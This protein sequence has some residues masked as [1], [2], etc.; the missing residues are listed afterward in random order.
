[1]IAR[2]TVGN[3][4]VLH[5]DGPISAEAQSL[6]LGVKE[7]ANNDIVV[8][9]LHGDMPVGIWE[10][11]AGALNRR[12]RG[13]RLVV[14]G[15]QQETVVL[16]G[17]WLSDRL[18]RTVIAPHGH[19]I[20]GAAGALF[21]HA[22]KASG[23]VR[24]R[25]GR[26]PAWEAKRFPQPAWDGAA[27]EF[28]P[29]SSVRAAEPLPGGV[30]IR[31]A[32]DAELVR[33]HWQW[34]VTAL[35][36][37]PESLAV[38]LGCPG[39]PALPLDDIARFW[40]GLDDENRQRVRFVHYGPVQVPRGES[41]GQVLADLLGGP[42]VCFGGV[43]VGTPEEPRM[44]TVGADGRLGWQV[45]A[46]ELSY[47][48][49]GRPTAPAAV[50]QMLSHRAPL[51]LGEPVA[52]MVYW[53]ANDAVVE[54]VQAG[55]W[56]RPMDPPK[57]A[58]E[59][60]AA[61]ADPERHVFV[62]DDATAARA[63]RMRALAEDV[64]A[65]LDP[66]TRQR[67]VL[68]AASTLAAAASITAPSVA[69]AGGQLG[70]AT[71]QQQS[72]PERPLTGPTIASGVTP[73]SPVGD[74]TTVP[75][76]VDV[77]VQVSGQPPPATVISA[78]PTA[79]AVAL[80]AWQ[81]SSVLLPDAPERPAASPAR[82]EP[83]RPQAPR[84]TAEPATAPADVKSPRPSEATPAQPAPAPSPA[85]RAR[86]QPVPEPAA[87]ALISG[88]ALDE[89]RSWLRRALSREFD[90]VA[91]SISRILS[92]QPGLQGD[93]A[94]SAAEILSDSVAV[95]LYLS[96]RGAAIDDA[97]RT[98]R[99][100]SHVPFARCVAAGLIR[101]PSHRGAT[102]FTAAPSPEQ[103]ELLARSRL[104]TEWGFTTALTAPS[105]DLTGAVDVLVWSMTAR[106]TRLLEPDGDEQADNRVLFVPGTSFKVLDVVEPG[107]SG[108][109]GQVL[110]R[111]LSANEIDADG[112][113]DRDRVS[114]D[115]L[116]TAS[117][118]RCAERWADT[119]PQSRVG[120]A[121]LSRFGALPGLA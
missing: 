82:P 74:T 4:L 72:D 81:T 14:C 41:L 113:V 90:A 2:H 49:R 20:R 56:M 114:F 98:A 77:P 1:M 64:V 93:T 79:E 11:V 109:R 15:Q 45:F 112:R 53:Y 107:P 94:K 24:Y 73:P 61:K 28:T 111:E 13:I 99:K 43:P 88:R 5:T 57:G 18:N 84:H 26:V 115:D 62:F 96:A 47:T 110:I 25:P 9:D 23:W 76:P 19:L 87:C 50:P 75:T 106:R 108:A 7:D 105:A 59:V 6:A 103:W 37:Q 97:L 86:Y 34:L 29:T 60:R 30:W 55:L 117:L 58:D 40:R 89:E 52:P 121:A 95:R 119:Q 63:A 3:A 102:V 67:S 101:L 54:V 92:E 104:L 27:A 33:E 38:I 51:V 46:R 44:H 31:D 16:A 39:T 118:R 71:D 66:A 42:V 100:G 17:Q 69:A 85:R 116:A 68:M 35:P 78:L 83:D 80:P 10:S 8:L 65:R 48:P 21:V 32:R 70:T 91:S 22:D 120:S 36:C 12:R